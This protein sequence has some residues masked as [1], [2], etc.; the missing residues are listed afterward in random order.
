M[1]H[2]HYDASHRVSQLQKE[3]LEAAIHNFNLTMVQPGIL[4]DLEDD[5]IFIR[6]NIEVENARDKSAVSP[7]RVKR[8]MTR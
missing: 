5:M 6:G 4:D 2:G 1:F 3:Q 7:T 8:Q